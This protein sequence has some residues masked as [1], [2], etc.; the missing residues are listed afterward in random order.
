VNAK[1]YWLATAAFSAAVLAMTS[2]MAAAQST[3]AENAPADQQR[4]SQ[5]IQTYKQA[6]QDSYL[7]ALLEGPEVTY[8]EVMANPDDPTLNAAYARTQIAHGDILGASVTLERLLLAH[9]DANEAR[10][11]YGMVLFRL[12][13]TVTAKDVLEAVDP[14]QLTP[15]QQDERT[16]ILAQ[17]ERRKKR[18]RQSITLTAG[19][20]FDTD[21]NAEPPSGNIL[22]NDLVFNLNGSARAQKDW[23]TLM[24]GSYQAEYDLGTDPRLSIY[25]SATA[26]H[27]QQARLKN[28][29]TQTGSGT[30]GLRYQDGPWSGEAGLFW[31]SM[32]LQSDYYLSDWGANARLAYYLLPELQAF[33]DLRYDRQ[34]FHNV[35]ADSQGSENSGTVPSEWLGLTWKPVPAHTIT[36]SAGVARRYAQ[37]N[38]MSNSRIAGRLGDVWL[39]GQGQFTSL[40][41][42][43]GV[44]VYDAPNGTVSSSTRRDHDMRYDLTYG[45]PAGTLAGF[46]G[47][48][49]PEELNDLVLSATAEYY[50]SFSTVMNYSYSNIRTQFLASKRWEF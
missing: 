22:F 36:A 17:I 31:N 5:G 25:G 33:T 43:Y 7:K 20:H 39:L 44:N 50:R 34:A 35:P 18:L 16:A 41:G 19:S 32:D 21:R 37:A 48:S 3:G 38:Y 24:Q 30:T 27:D 14:S 10:L 2:G 9:P 46:A 15:Q 8:D 13:D 45:L 40:T 23:G 11:V 12:D 47:G 4:L 42:E 49:L 26:M 29:D 28:F 1:S 6:T